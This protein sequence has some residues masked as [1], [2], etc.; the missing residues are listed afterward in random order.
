VEG[1]SLP[2]PTPHD[3]A[4][5]LTSQL[6]R[7]FFVTFPSACCRFLLVWSYDLRFEAFYIRPFCVKTI[8]IAEFHVRDLL[9]C[10][11]Y[12]SWRQPC[13]RSTE[14]ETT[15]SQ[16]CSRCVRIIKH[17]CNCRLTVTWAW[18]CQAQM[19]NGRTERSCETSRTL[20]FLR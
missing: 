5:V 12:N 1:T 9:R 4:Q 14:P 13:L 7:K 20:A 18:T 17:S 15:D 19:P 16:R 3:Q 10:S 8:R 11:T 2:V 6:G